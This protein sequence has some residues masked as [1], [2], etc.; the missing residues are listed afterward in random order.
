MLLGAPSSSIAM[1]SRTRGGTCPPPSRWT[2]SIRRSG[3]KRTGGDED[4][5]A[6]VS[7]RHA[8]AGYA[9][10]SSSPR[11]SSSFRPRQRSHPPARRRSSRRATRDGVASVDDEARLTT[12][13]W[14]RARRHRPRYLSG[15]RM[16]LDTRVASR[17][18]RWR[19]HVARGVLEHAVVVEAAW[20]DVAGRHPRGS[21]AGRN[22]SSSSA[23]NMTM[24][25]AALKGD[26]GFALPPTKADALVESA[27]GLRTSSSSTRRR[28][29]GDAAAMRF[30]QAADTV[31]IVLENGC[32]LVYAESV[33]DR[34][35]FSGRWA[36][37]IVCSTRPARRP[38]R[39]ARSAWPGRPLRGG[40]P[41]GRRRGSTSRRRPIPGS[42]PWRSAVAGAAR[43]RNAGPWTLAGFASRDASARPGTRV[44][45]AAAPAELFAGWSRVRERV[46][47]MLFGLRCSLDT[48]SRARPR[49]PAPGPR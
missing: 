36:G 49:T 35:S 46:A 25:E 47:A 18:W 42:E 13:A 8:A 29:S 41:V 22:R 7:G 17:P 9:A 23:K 27:R 4:E 40:R 45:P 39:L 12:C 43:R 16:P 38:T 11:L 3:G 5:A 28:S 48:P 21:S 24:I 34:L 44:D 10:G 6:S 15:G 19:S 32:W 14:T 2:R 31:L 20:S 33:I 1:R 30:A 26:T 37:S